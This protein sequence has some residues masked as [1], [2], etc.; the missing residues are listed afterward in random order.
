MSMKKSFFLSILSLTSLLL[1]G[2]GRNKGTPIDEAAF[3]EQTMNI[4][5]ND[6]EY[7]KANV[8]YV[9]KVENNSSFSSDAS[10]KEENELV[11]NYDKEKFE[12]VTDSGLD[13]HNIS[14]V[15][16]QDMLS[17]SFYFEEVYELLLSIGDPNS[18]MYDDVDEK[19]KEE[20]GNSIMTIKER[21][22]HYYAS[23]YG[24][25]LFC[26]I[27]KENKDKSEEPNIIDRFES[28]M[29]YEFNEYGYVTYMNTFEKTIAY[30]NENNVEESVYFDCEID[31][32]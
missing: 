31:Y 10:E 23:P 22:I 3:K 11:F 25:E 9:Y 21:Y 27:D 18:P 15:V 6:I 16:G 26:A 8:K 7:K 5:D 13:T 4:Y 24:I 20:M 28:Y 32:E 2:C 14:S 29:Y 30:I 19:T 12:W 17:I 1:V